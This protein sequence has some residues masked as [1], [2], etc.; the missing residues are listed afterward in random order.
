MLNPLQMR[1]ASP[2]GQYGT[3]P[4][5]ISGKLGGLHSPI[6]PG[7]FGVHIRDPYSPIHKE[8]N[9]MMIRPARRFNTIMEEYADVRSRFDSVK[10]KIS[11][12]PNA[13]DG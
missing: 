13:K 11:T 3:T 4:K 10:K 8:I 7:D 5:G 1:N 2:M 9:E 6:L 12:D